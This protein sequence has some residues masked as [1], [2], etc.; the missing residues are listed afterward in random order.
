MV[1]ENDISFK[2]INLACGGKLCIREGWVNAD[3]SPSA[4]S[5]MKLNLLKPLPFSDNSFDVV[6]HAQF[7]EHLPIEL[8]H[9]FLNECYR[10]LKPGGILRVVT[11]DLENQVKEYLKQLNAVRSRT[12]GI[13]EHANYD[14]IRLELLD[15]LTRNNSG[16]EMTSFISERG[17][18]AQSYIVDRLGRS[19]RQLFPIDNKAK[20]SII[21][22]CKRELKAMFQSLVAVISPQ[23]FRVG[24]F[25]TE[26]EAHLCMY[27]SYL[28]TELLKKTGFSNID[29]VS[30]KQSSIPNWEKTLLDN[31]AEGVPDCPT[32]LFMEAQKAN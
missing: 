10:V 15:Q 12:S 14:W 13:Q 5:V 25:R 17:E 2:A 19:G 11:P 22:A 31:D 30:Y 8:A 26:G 29:V 6:Y 23:W 16:G 21:A 24:K 4:E 27:D 32:S 3:H 28:L 20:P 7:I 18:D 1:V 9:I